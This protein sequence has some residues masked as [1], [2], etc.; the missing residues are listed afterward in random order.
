[1]VRLPYHWVYI[2]SKTPLSPCFDSLV[3]KQ[4]F[5]PKT[6]LRHYLYIRPMALNNILSEIQAAMLKYEKDDPIV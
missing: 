4:V 3:V 1:M 6:T 5:L 2:S